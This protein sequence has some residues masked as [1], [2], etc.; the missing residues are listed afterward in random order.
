MM[1]RSILV[2]LCVIGCGEPASESTAP[3]APDAPDASPTVGS[4]AVSTCE[5]PDVLVLLDRT[6]SMAERP[7]GTLPADTAAG[8]TESKWFIA[9][10]A[11]EALSR[12]LESS[13]RFGLALFP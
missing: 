13:V 7:D 12:E 2:A 8:H 5:A 3:D 6:A 11:V 4:D 9:I 10:Q 1:K